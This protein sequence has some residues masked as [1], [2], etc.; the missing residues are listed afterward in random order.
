MAVYYIN[1]EYG[2]DENSGL[3]EDCPL[4]SHQ[5]LN[6][7]PGD[8]VLFKRGSF[9]RDALWNVSGEEG[10]PITYS[11]YGEGENPVFCGSVD[12]SCEK[13][14]KEI[15]ENIW[16]CTKYLETEVCNFVFNQ[17]ECGALRWDR[18]KLI[19]QGDWW[20]NCYGMDEEKPDPEKH[21]VLL[22]SKINPSKYY[23]HIECVLRSHRELANTGHD[24]II[25]DLTFRNNGV[26]GI[27]G[28]KGARNL[29]I[30]N[31][32]FEYIGGN[33][34]NKEREIRFGNAIEFWD[35]AENVLVEHCVFY[36]IYDSGITHQ[37]YHDS[38]KPAQNMVCRNNIFM[39]CGM[40]AYEQRDV[41]PKSACFEHNVCADA[42][43]GFSGLGEEVPRNSEIWP[44][45]MGHHVFLWRIDKP[46]ENACFEIKNNIFMEA[47]Y[48]K[49][50]YAIIAKEAQ[51]QIN[52]TENLFYVDE[53]LFSKKEGAI[54]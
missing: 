21:V 32:R 41:L 8:K 16:Q 36:E 47:P 2:S 35:V 45:P 29:Q 10:C 5:N 18:S 26:H 53:L 11:A 51:E 20:D 39:K 43:K 9:V 17:Q 22:Y 1:P 31:C 15:E 25:S 44:E 14:W 46:T 34:W 24:M 28:E 54:G 30:I 3:N 6:I 38:C 42:G 37:G 40:S 19:N 12:V 52:F 50:M 48:G 13:D 33:V 4:K 23:G 49:A 7:L 27:A